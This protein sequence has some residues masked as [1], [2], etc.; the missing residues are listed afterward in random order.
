[1][2]ACP[3]PSRTVDEDAIE[4]TRNFGVCI[5]GLVAK[6]GCSGG[7]DVHHI[8]TRGSGGGDT[9]DN[10]I[11]LCRKHH[12]EAH[13]GLISKDLLRAAVRHFYEGFA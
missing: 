4:K 13:M 10:L 5:Y 2:A 8:K 11:L 3:K 12:Q 7:L 6:D 1:M 9:G